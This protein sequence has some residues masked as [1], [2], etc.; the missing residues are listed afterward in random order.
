[1]TYKIKLKDTKDNIFYIIEVGVLTDVTKYSPIRNSFKKLHDRGLLTDENIAFTQDLNNAK[2]YI[3][4]YVR[5]GSQ[6]TYG[7]ISVGK[8]K[9]DFIREHNGLLYDRDN[10]EESEL[11]NYLLET[12]LYKKSNYILFSVYKDKYSIDYNTFY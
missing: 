3:E 9:T 11:E 12:Y 5:S 4:R 7:V 10:F 6:G 1:M 2:R 8:L